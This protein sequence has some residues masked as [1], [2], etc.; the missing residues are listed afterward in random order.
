MDKLALRLEFEKARQL[1]PGDKNGE[2]VAWKY[3]CQLKRFKGRWSEIVPLLVPAIKRQIEH[4]E[5]ATGFVPAWKGFGSWIYN[6]Y[7]TRTFGVKAKNAPKVCKNC[8][9]PS[10]GMYGNN[11]YCPKLEC[12]AAAG[13]ESAKF[14]LKY[15]ISS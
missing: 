2:D 15:V 12:K 4:R 9:A 7:W 6:S 5:N 13:D 3:F 1:Y 8:G 14:L 10:T 11:T